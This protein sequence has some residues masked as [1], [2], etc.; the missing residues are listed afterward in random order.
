MRARGEIAGDRKAI[1]VSK[2]S[3]ALSSPKVTSLAPAGGKGMGSFSW[4]IKAGEAQRP[5][6]REARLR[7]WQPRPARTHRRTLGERV[8]EDA[9]AGGPRCLLGA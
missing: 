7:G 1:K 5:R 4:A 6:R 2:K 3:A 9:Q 8:A